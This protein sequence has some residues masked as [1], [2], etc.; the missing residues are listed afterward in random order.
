MS[1][2]QYR[3]APKF[4]VNTMLKYHV[5]ICTHHSFCA[6]YRFKWLFSV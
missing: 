1:L 3:T 5:E 4:K 6:L 2:E